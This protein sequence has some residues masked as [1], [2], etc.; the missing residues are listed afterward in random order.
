Q[1][2]NPLH[3]HTVR[4]EQYTYTEYSDHDNNI[5][6]RMLYDVL[7]DPEENINLSEKEE[8][9]KVVEELSNMLKMIEDQS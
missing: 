1:K 7:N 4:T 9:R 2:S 3:G 5:V 8:C 6:A